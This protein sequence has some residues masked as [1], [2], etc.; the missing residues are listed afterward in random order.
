MPLVDIRIAQNEIVSEM[1]KEGLTRA[2]LIG[3]EKASLSMRNMERL[4]VA[5]FEKRLIAELKIETLALNALTEE[6]NRTSKKLS[7]LTLIL[8]RIVNITGQL[9]NIFDLVK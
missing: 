3:L 6:I 4:L 2:E 8:R 7:E 5:T 9:I 1:A